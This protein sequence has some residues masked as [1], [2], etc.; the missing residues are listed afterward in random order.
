MTPRLENL[1]WTVAENYS[2]KAN[3]DLFNKSITEEYRAILL[4]GYYKYFN[5]PLIEDFFNSYLKSKSNSKDLITI[6]ELTLENAVRDVLLEERPGIID[7]RTEY[8]KIMLHRYETLYSK[9]ISDEILKG[10][11][12]Y[13]NNIVP[14]LN[15]TAKKLLDDI[16]AFKK[17]DTYDFLQFMKDIMDRYFH[18]DKSLPPLEE[19]L[20]T[21]IDLS[22]LIKE[23]KE[24]G[25]Y[26]AN[27]TS[28]RVDVETLEKYTIQSA[29]FTSS[30]YGDSNFLV[31]EA[32]SERSPV[33]VDLF[34]SVKKHY[35]ESYLN[36]QSTLELEKTNCTGI[37]E[38]VKLHFT[39]GQFEN[40]N[41]YYKAKID[42]SYEENLILFNS[43]E[44]HYRRG[45]KNLAETIRNS[46]LKN[47]ESYEVK[48]LN[49]ELIAGSVWK[50]IYTSD[51][52]IFEKKFTDIYGD[53]SV[54][55][56]LDSSASQNER[57]S[58]IAIQGYIITEAL[59]E[60]NIKTRVF[61]Y[62]N[63]FNYLV[64]HKYRDYNDDKSKNLNIFKYTASGSN[65][66]GLAI[67]LMTSFIEKNS[68]ERRIL[69]IL[70][71][72]KPNDDTNLGLVGFKD[73]GVSNYVGE[74]AKLDTYNK[75]SMA[76]LKGI[77]VLGV[78]TGHEEDLETEKKIYGNDFAYI[79]D[80]K[81]FHQIV[82][83]FLKS[84]ADKIN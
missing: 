25:N 69:I 82:G 72:G 63:F 71:D 31:E 36:R 27:I 24:T 51:D 30:D 18:I 17:L 53:I 80:L 76:K 61:G 3:F 28:N 65:R 75:V 39:K 62:N 42:K 21:L 73:L 44:L 74:V 19:K 9:D 33:N 47:T 32:P 15:L 81:R 37:H 45:I 60:L 13:R 57:E 59:T 2:F 5:I 50:S 49:G 54:D 34:K 22:K 84:V 40:K 68:H 66:D 16:L 77:Y 48:S 38:G 29:E 1:T 79:T 67:K 23:N 12:E 46:L 56:L 26:V 20:K 64:M 11:Y 7:F 58:E 83:I 6:A 78:F 52:K 55:I 41:S 10:F 35:G 4:G 70:S 43:D 14:K 8:E